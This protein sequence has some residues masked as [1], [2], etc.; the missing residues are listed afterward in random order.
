[1]NLKGKTA[2]V[3]GATGGMGS[4]IVNKLSEEGVRCVLVARKKSHLKK[5]LGSLSGKGHVYYSVDLTKPKKIISLT[6]KIS[7]RF[8]TIDILLNAAGIGIY[9]NLED[10]SLKEWKITYALNTVAPFLFAKGIHSSL[11]SSKGSVVF[12]F[13]SGCGKEPNADRVAYNSS[14][15]ALRGL[16]LSNFKDFEKTNVNHVL[17]TL[18]SVMTSFGKGGLKRRK[19]L[20]RKG[21]EYLT[22]EAVGNKIIRVL[23]S[24]KFEEEIV[25]YPHHY[26]KEVEKS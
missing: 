22:P 16:A 25:Y 13:G 15:F 23:K 24:G 26:K 2:V 4:V 12:Y 18:G 8:K 14:K 1:M 19:K 6:K 20:Q 10:I 7:K 3:V 5:L 11:R 21:R 9:K 17:L